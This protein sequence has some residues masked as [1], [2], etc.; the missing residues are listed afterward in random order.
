MARPTKYSKS[1][2]KKAR[3]YLESCVDT[4]QVVGSAPRLA[5]RK[6]VKVPTVEGLALALNISR[7]TVYAW[8]NDKD[9]PEF[10]DT[11]ERLQI[12]QADRLIQG[13]LS[14]EYKDSIVKLILS[15][16]TPTSPR[17][18]PGKSTTGIS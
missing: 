17:P 8:A 11:L 12:V 7:D 4:F 3:A 2:A 15:L 6:V 5:V 13:G 10:S 9:K 16:S 18:R 14:S 1:M